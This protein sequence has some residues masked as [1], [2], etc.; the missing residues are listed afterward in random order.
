[1]AGVAASVAAAAA[2]EAAAAGAAVWA[3]RA[4]VAAAAKS[5]NWQ[6]MFH[7][8]VAAAWH[9]ANAI[10]DGTFPAARY[11]EQLCG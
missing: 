1:V 6:A 5:D 10:L 3:A 11:D 2:A 8:R 7:A 4:A 9:R